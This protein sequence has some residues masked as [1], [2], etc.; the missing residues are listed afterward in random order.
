MAYHPRIESTDLASFLTTR[1]RNAELWFINNPRLENAIL[2]YTAKLADRYNVKLYALAIEGNHIQGP[3]L[4]PLGN[5]SN[6]MRDLNSSIAKAV[7]KHTPE[8]PGGRLWER[9]YSSEFLPDAEDVEEYFFYTVLQPIKDGL[10]E[11]LSDYPGYNCFYDAIHGISK[12]FE[13]V[14]WT[15]FNLA[16]RS[17]PEAKIKHFTKTVTLQYERLPGYD[18]LTQAE[19]VKMMIEKFECR[20]REILLERYARGLGF[21]GRIKIKNTKRGSLPVNSKKADSTAKRPRILS[22]SNERRAEFKN[23][24]FSIYNEYKRASL[25][26]RNGEWWVE[27]PP[28]TFRPSVSANPRK[29]G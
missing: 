24:Y 4:F 19:Y 28:G 15:E 8:Y 17:N 18:N 12:K 5:R 20:R 14:N 26:Y 16:R 13:I 9:R 7:G 29:M 11:K 1:T 25:L 22:I 6:F 27:F 23:W 21:K 10:V 2:G 3:A